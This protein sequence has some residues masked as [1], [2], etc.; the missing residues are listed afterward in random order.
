MAGFKESEQ[1][2]GE[3]N[4]KRVRRCANEEQSKYVCPMNGCKKS[5]G[6]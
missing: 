4:V 6:S 3:E 2:V 1:S 5:Y